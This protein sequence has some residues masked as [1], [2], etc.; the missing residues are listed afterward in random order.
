MA[1]GTNGLVFVCNDEG[2]V[3]SCRLASCRFDTEPSGLLPR[4]AGHRLR[5]KP[6]GGRIATTCGTACHPNPGKPMV[7]V[8]L[9]SFSNERFARRIGWASPYRSGLL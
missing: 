1:G 6:S 5:W 2:R 8:G 7:T 9:P 4:Q 3:A